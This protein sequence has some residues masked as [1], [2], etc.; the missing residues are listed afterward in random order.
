ME[1]GE[2][3]RITCQQYNR[4]R[5]KGNVP[6]FTRTHL[7]VHLLEHKRPGPQQVIHIEYVIGQVVTGEDT[8]ASQGKI[9]AI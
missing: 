5:E 6:I 7:E 8:K 4:I 1:I 2:R 9:N 3:F